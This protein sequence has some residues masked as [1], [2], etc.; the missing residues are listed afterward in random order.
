MRTKR[1]SVTRL[2]QLSGLTPTGV[3]WRKNF[4]THIGQVRYLLTILQQDGI[5]PGTH[6]NPQTLVEIDLD[7]DIRRQLEEQYPESSWQQRLQLALEQKHG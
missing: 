4:A 5:P 3:W 2:A 7:E 1:C 6:Y